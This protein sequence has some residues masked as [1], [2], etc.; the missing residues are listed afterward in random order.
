MKRL[1]IITSLFV[2]TN[3]FAT[4]QDV[5]FRSQVMEAYVKEHVGIGDGENLNTVQLDTITQIDLSGLNLTAISD[6]KY[7]INVRSLDLSNNKIENIAPIVTLDS[8]RE[9]NLSHN[10]LKTIS[11]LSF[12]YAKKMYVNVAF[13]YIKD[14]SCFNTL[15]NCDFTI[16]GANM[17]YDGD[18]SFFDVDYF[19]CNVQSGTPVI[20]CRVSSEDKAILKLKNEETEV[21]IDRSHFK[22][23]LGNDITSAAPVYLISGEK[24]DSTYYLP[25]SYCRVD[26]GKTIILKVELPKNYSLSSVNAQYGNAVMNGNTIS[27]TAP[28]SALP[29]VID[30]SYNLGSTLKGIS[31]FCVNF[32]GD[33]MSSDVSLV[34]YDVNGDEVTNVKDI[35]DVVNYVRGKSDLSVSA[36]DVN[37]DGTVDDNDVNA[38]RDAILDPTFTMPEDATT[39]I[40]KLVNNMLLVSGGT[41][42]M[43]ATDGWGY[44]DERPTHQ[45]YV[46]AYKIS[47]Y[48]VSQKLW[49]AVMGSNPSTV[50]GDN[51]PVNNISWGDCQT[52]ISRLNEL[53]K[54]ITDEKFCLPTEAQW[55]FAAR[56][57]TYRN[58]LE[59]GGNG[60]QYAGGYNNIEDMEPYVWCSDNSGG[61]IHP[62]GSKKPNEL[63]LYDMS[64]NVCEYVQDYFS[65]S[66]PEEAQTNPTGESSGSKYVYR[67]GSYNRPK[68]QCRIAS[69]FGAD[70]ETKLEECGLRLVISVLV[71]QTAGLGTTSDSGAD[72][73]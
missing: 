50:V 55:E 21:P 29:D 43:G 54:G 48:E 5:K 68:W 52:F 38:V 34:D 46:S 10:N 16:A 72:E 4:A 25:I 28:E 42:T 35:V 59:N 65:S 37:G 67:G 1:L 69:R 15:T 23:E 70:P 36:V 33:K 53:S 57:G 73:V 11:M 7:L 8:L 51:L 27:Y 45:V 41:F 58:D 31:R 20:S 60:Y 62:I 24:K 49:K 71:P 9:V 18:G 32:E 61:T 66:Y 13:N 40:K 19:V 30:F 63:G 22:H 44:S 64:G 14:F 26:A 17:Q 47:R 2:M 12:S 56:G 3:V 39:L 6:I